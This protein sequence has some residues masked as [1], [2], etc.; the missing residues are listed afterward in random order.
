MTGCR[1]MKRARKPERRCRWAA[2]TE[3][4]TA[5][6]RLQIEWKMVPPVRAPGRRMRVPELEAA[7]ECEE[8]G[9]RTSSPTCV[10][11]D[12][13]QAD[14]CDIARSPQREGVCWRHVVIRPGLWGFP[15]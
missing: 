8:P 4:D 3:G 15:Y 12:R 11:R 5:W 6:G 10:L 2:P 9:E 13:A 7:R 14:V 1:G